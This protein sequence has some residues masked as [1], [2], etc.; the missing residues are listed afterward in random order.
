MKQK[1]KILILEAA[2]A[3][4]AKGL[5]PSDDFPDVLVEV[6][7]VKSQGDFS[8]NLA[9]TMAKIQ[10]MA[11][12]KIAEI[13]LDNIDADAL[14]A[15]SEIA[16]PGFI[17]FFLKT[18]AWIPV[19]HEVHAKDERY[20]ESVVGENRK[21][22]V[23]FVSSNPTGPLHVGHGRGAA[24]GDSTANILSFCGYDVQKEYYINDS[25]RQI[26]TLGLSVYLRGRELLGQT[27][28]FPETCYQGGYI[29]D[30]AADRFEAL[31]AGSHPAG[32][33]HPLAIEALTAMDIPLEEQTSKS[34]DEFADRVVDVVIT[35]CHD[36]ASETCPAWPGAPIRAHWSLPDPSYLPGTDEERLAMTLRV[37]QRLRTKIQ[38][39][40]DLDWSTDRPQIEERL[41]FL[42]EI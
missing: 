2:R 9:M 13:L 24:V 21:I 35:V 7:K 32:F 14:I 34:W 23:E 33:V 20:G 40:I 26:Q 22:Q 27:V 41:R 28:D 3:A 30:L 29:R 12:R 39:L 36:A 42:G 18:N 11:P 5:L 8:T 38:G 4:H 16:G 19:L 10:K 6:P 31:S 25:G 15:K 17:N 1:L 37:A